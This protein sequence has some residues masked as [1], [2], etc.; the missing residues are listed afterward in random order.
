MKVAIFT[1]YYFP[2]ISGVVTH[3]KTLKEGLEA[4]GHE[5]L[6]V[7]LDPKGKRHYMKDNILYCPA[8]EVKKL[9]GYGVANPIN[10]RR[11]VILEAFAPDIIHM[12]TEFTM[13][14]FANFAAKRM[15]V[16][17]V[18]TLHT[19][20]DDYLFYVLPNR[21]PARMKNMAKPI[22]HSYIRRV[23]NTATEVIG[24]SHKVVDYL[25]RCGVKRHINIV[26]NT[27]DMHDFLPENISKADIAA[28]KSKLGIK[29][30]DVAVAFVGRLGKEKSID[31]L[32]DYFTL[33]FRGEE[34]FKLFIA[35]DGPELDELN[36]L[37]RRLKMESQ[38]KLLGRVEHEQVPAFYG[39]CDLFATASLTEM[40]SISMIEANAAGLYVAQ[41]LDILNRDQIHSGEN[42]DVYTNS[43]EFNV[44]LRE[45]AKLDKKGRTARKAQV[46]AFAQRYG[47]KEFTEAIMNVYNRA[48][49]EYK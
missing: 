34:Q 10:M 9:Y 11:M 46:S 37:V 20:Y 24:P 21:T 6:I 49:Y 1:E 28:W 26:P 39:A 30:N 3:I 14:I 18:Y 2:Y 7:T 12:H 17:T 15:K 48:I 33:C 40:N 35:G 42:G 16:P 25:H 22:A 44:I 47:P 31:V 36:H 23:A 4:Q 45:Y 29:E 38:I 43:E 5:V 27:V 8:L 41:R 19:M 13:G 32:I